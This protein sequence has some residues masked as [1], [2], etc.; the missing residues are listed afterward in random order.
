MSRIQKNVHPL[1]TGRRWCQLEQAIYVVSY[2]S[3]VQ[4]L[5]MHRGNSIRAVGIRRPPRKSR[6]WFAM[7]PHGYI[8]DW[9]LF[10]TL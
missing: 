5:T 2:P 3:V 4:I 9:R 8:K 1:I 10:E 7:Q 6:R